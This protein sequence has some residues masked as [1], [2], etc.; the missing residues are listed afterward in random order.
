MVL[1]LLLSTFFS[2]SIFAA[3][4]THCDGAFSGSELTVTGCNSILVAGN[5]TGACYDFFDVELM[6][7]QTITISVSTNGPSFNPNIS[8]WSNS[9]MF[10]VQEVCFPDN[11]SAQTIS[12]SFTAPVDGLYRVEISDFL[13]GIDGTDGSYELLV[14]GFCDDDPTTMT[15][16][17][18]TMGEWGLISLAFLLLIFSITAIKQEELTSQLA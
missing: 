12:D 18:P 17:I 5:C 10:N 11:A 15:T 9:P 7:G 13:S 14:E 4:A 16:E 6:A 3:Y 2:I 8:V 1:R